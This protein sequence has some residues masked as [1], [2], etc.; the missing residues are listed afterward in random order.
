MWPN[1]REALPVAFAP[2]RWTRR[3]DLV[4]GGW[5]PSP[6]RGGP[7]A[8]GR[9]R[10]AVEAV[11]I[12]SGGG[13]SRLLHRRASSALCA[14]RSGSAPVTG[15]SGGAGAVRR[16]GLSSR[17]ATQVNGV[18]VLRVTPVA[19]R[20][21]PR[22]RPARAHSSASAPRPDCPLS[23]SAPLPGTAVVFGSPAR[24]RPLRTLP[25]RVASA[26]IGRPGGVPV[27]AAP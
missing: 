12:G 7:R 24:V 15:G 20:P 25:G 6:G 4:C 27:S 18:S 19:P 16:H 2:S 8:E 23:W 14:P 1:A 9:L 21:A 5:I 11:V 10:P 13:R 3:G 26:V 17:S 22:C